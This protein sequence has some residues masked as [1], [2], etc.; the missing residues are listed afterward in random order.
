MSAL[1]TYHEVNFD[2]KILLLDENSSVGGVW[3]EER[4]YDGLNTNNLVGAIEYSDF[5]MD[6]ATFGV[7]P[8]AHVPGSVIHQYLDKYVRHFGCWGYIRLGHRVE[9]VERLEDGTWLVGNM[10]VNSS[11]ASFPSEVVAK[12]LLMATG[13]T[14]QP[15]VP[16]FAGQE[17]FDTPL[18]HFKDLPR[19][20]DEV[21]QPKQQHVAQKRVAVLGAS[22]SGWDAVYLCATSGAQVDWIIRESGHGPAWMAPPYVTPFK[23]WLERL[24]TTRLL[25]WMSPCVWGDADGFGLVRRFLH[26]TWLG[27]K[28]V[29]GFWHVLTQDVV[30]LNGYDKHPE[31]GKLKPWI[32]AFWAASSFSIVNYPTNFF[33]LIKNGTVRVHVADIDHL[34]KR[35]VHLSTGETL[36]CDGM[37]CST[38]WRVVPKI[39]FLPVGIDRE[40]GF[41]WSE[42]PLNA[43]MIEQAGQEIL[44]RFPR[45]QDQP[46]GNPHYKPLSVDAAALAPHPYRLS[47]FMVPLGIAD[48]SIIF[49]GVALSFGTAMMAQIQALWA[50]AYLTNRLSL[51]ARETCPADMRAVQF[52][53]SPLDPDLAW[54]MALHTEFCKIRYPAGFGKRNPDFVFDSIPFIDVL[55]KDL[56][57][58]SQRKKGFIAQCF[59]SHTVADYRGLVDEWKAT[60]GP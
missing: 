45:L 4:L 49:V 19:F 53:L 43:Q 11:A 34:S 10:P 17:A 13:P 23:K 39:R 9:S 6:E 38:G 3:A 18:M 51:T 14:S 7:P 15:I 56:G 48:H 28:I 47:R 58:S 21:T 37:I 57:L 44:R 32:S 40:L 30:D 42:D 46:R 36:P 35:T 54:E 22:K 24:V 59:R 5:P 33:D 31:V 8:G 50:T 1:K 2:A 25:T 60:Q 27:R 20:E 55:L 16:H 12:K 26:G 41:P 52:K 29:D